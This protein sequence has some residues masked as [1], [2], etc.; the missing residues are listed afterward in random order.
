[1]VSEDGGHDS[2]GREIF[3][4]GTRHKVA[5]GIIAW[6]LAFGVPMTPWGNSFVGYGLIAAA[7][8][9]ALA[10]LTVTIWRFSAGIRYQTISSGHSYSKHEKWIRYSLVG[11]FSFLCILSIAAALQLSGALQTRPPE[12]MQY[13]KRWKTESGSAIAVVNTEPLL[14]F[15]DSHNLLL[16]IRWADIE[17]TLEDHTTILKSRFFKITGKDVIVDVPITRAFMKF[18][19]PALNF[20]LLLVPHKIIHDDITRVEDVT[21]QGGFLLTS[22]GAGGI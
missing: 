22:K 13:L 14:K 1:M 11:M 12:E 2:F 16:I 5:I 9:T 17:G 10:L 21:R 6:L 20:F 8:L 18:Y 19:K 4:W 15:A 7:L 3:L